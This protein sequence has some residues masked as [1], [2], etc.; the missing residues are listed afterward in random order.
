MIKE[1][2]FKD[3]LELLDFTEKNTIGW[4]IALDMLE[5]DYIFKSEDL[6]VGDKVKLK[7]NEDHEAVVVEIL[8]IFLESM[9]LPNT[10]RFEGASLILGFSMILLNFNKSFS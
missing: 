5:D 1:E 7:K 9:Y 10:A 8:K 2:Q 3:Y 6:D 4:F